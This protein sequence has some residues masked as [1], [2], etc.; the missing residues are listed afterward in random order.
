MILLFK[1][2]A[3]YEA[4][5]G[6][7][8]KTLHNLNAD[9]NFNFLFHVFINLMYIHTYI[10]ICTHVLN[11]KGTLKVNYHDVLT[12]LCSKKLLTGNCE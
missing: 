12:Q 6:K 1:L 11:S 10:Y 2:G 5:S 4:Q 7:K 8:V 3:S 9:F